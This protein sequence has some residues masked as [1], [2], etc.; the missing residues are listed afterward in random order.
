MIIKLSSLFT[1]AILS[2]VCETVAKQ[3]SWLIGFPLV[4]TAIRNFSWKMYFMEL[5]Q[6][7]AVD[8]SS[9]S[10]S[11][12][13]SSWCVLLYSF[14]AH[15]AWSHCAVQGASAAISQDLTE[16]W[17]LMDFYQRCGGKLGGGCLIFIDSE[18]DCELTAPQLSWNYTNTNLGLRFG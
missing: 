10:L 15:F 9:T 4:S 18:K 14:T 11:V 13:R 2:H 6:T 12:R 5:T 1:T 7:T 3:V 17:F 8:V 16:W